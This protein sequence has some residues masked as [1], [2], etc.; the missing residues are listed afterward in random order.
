MAAVEDDA[1]Q[2]AVE[3]AVAA[4]AESVPLS[5]AA[6]GGDG[7]DAGEAG[8]AGLGAEPAWVRPGD[9]QLGGDD[10]SDARFVERGWRECAD[11]GEDL[12]LELVS[13]DRCRLD[14]AGEAAQHDP[15]RELVGA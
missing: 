1:V 13:F 6:G 4:A 7:C 8:E 12:L 2:G 11:V 3:L 5:L 10:R 14:A 15:C 9:D